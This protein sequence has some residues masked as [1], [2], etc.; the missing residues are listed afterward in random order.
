[1]LV[2]HLEIRGHKKD[3]EKTTYYLRDIDGPHAPFQEFS[4]EI[5]CYNFITNNYGPARQFALSNPM[6]QE[7]MY[8]L[9]SELKSRKEYADMQFNTLT[10]EVDGEKMHFIYVES[11]HVNLA[12]LP[13][14]QFPISPK[15]KSISSQEILRR[16]LNFPFP[17]IAK[18]NNVLEYKRNLTLEEFCA[19]ETIG[20][21]SEYIHW[22][23]EVNIDRLDIEKDVLIKFIKT[24]NIDSGLK[25]FED[26]SQKELAKIVIDYFHN[27]KGNVELGIYE[28]PMAVQIQHV[29]DDKT[30]V[31]YY[32]YILSEDLEEEAELTSGKAVITSHK[33]NSLDEMMNSQIEK[34][35]DIGALIIVN[36]NGPK[37][38]FLKGREHG[39][40]INE[41]RP[42]MKTAAGFFPQT[43]IYGNYG[44]DIS[45]YSQSY[46][47]FTIDN[48]YATICTLILGKKFEKS[49]GYDDLS[50]LS[51]E[52]LLGNKESAKLLKGYSVDDVAPFRQIGEFLKPIIYFKSMLFG[53]NPDAAVSTSKSNLA[54]D[55][56]FYSRFKKTLIFPDW[57]R[58]NNEY[59]DFDGHDAFLNLFDKETIGALYRSTPKILD[60]AA[61][62]YL[63]PFVR[64]YSTTEVFKDNKIIQDMLK[65][66]KEK[67]GLAL[68]DIIN[69]LE[70]GYLLPYIFEDSKQD[71]PKTD[72]SK[73]TGQFT[74]FVDMFPPMNRSGNFYCFRIDEADNEEFKKSILHLGFEVARGDIYNIKRGSFILHDGLNIFK[75][76]N[77]AKGTRGWK[78]AFQ[79]DISQEFL[80]RLFS[81]GADDAIS[82]VS[83]RIQNLIKGKVDLEELTYLI[84]EVPRDYA[85]YSSYAQRQ[86]RVKAIIQFKKKKGER[87]QYGKIL[88]ERVEIDAFLKRKDEV[89]SD[90]NIELMI[91]DSLGIYTRSGRNFSKGKIG[92]YLEPLANYFGIT[93]E[94]LFVKIVGKEHIYK[95]IN[96]KKRASKNPDNG[97]LEL[98]N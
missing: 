62:F 47:P 58:K 29:K 95:D 5:Y 48:K 91:D 30:I 98:F 19:L 17:V 63:A 64:I 81:Q 59:L 39:F 40:T 55:A 8:T 34:L 36:A 93:K 46:L 83:E 65:Y 57:K 23:K 50:R 35:E 67:K 15:A 20:Y 73:V 66:A 3:T 31:E 78:N 49:Q 56:Y 28:K 85:N 77:D 16:K 10:R 69:T 92:R 11:L 97:Q 94:D 45:A 41:K 4:G 76:E 70:D 88:E 42:I 27:N 82:Y 54:R 89:F 87:L 1:M 25:N 72:I 32:S 90:E 26:A 51:R 18:K 71:F 13:K 38:D 53:V 79:T 68:F 96:V 86:E 60:K 2:T 75:R 24:Q 52:M 12:L 22:E 43:V 61:L 37:Y 9:L 21:D 84:K 74:D 14:Y 33:S 44:V 7:K 80:S 6:T